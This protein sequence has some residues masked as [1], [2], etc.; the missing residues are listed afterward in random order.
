MDE[1]R[2]QAAYKAWARAQAECRAGARVRAGYTDEQ[3]EYKAVARA[4][5]KVGEQVVYRA[6]ARA[7][8]RF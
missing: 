8:Y 5:C 1:E 2:A 3:V 6:V 4:V 7:G